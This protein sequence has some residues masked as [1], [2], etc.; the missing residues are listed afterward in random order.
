VEILSWDDTLSVGIAPID[1][2]H[3]LICAMINDLQKVAGACPGVQVQILDQHLSELLSAIRQHFASEE[4]L[5]LE[6][7]FPEHAAHQ[8]LHRL[9]E[10]RL[11]HFR[12]TGT[13]VVNVALVDFLRQWFL[14][15]LQIEDQKY[16]EFLKAH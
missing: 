4:R 7:A 2:E 5:L 12:I 6:A 10:A 3:R 15:H 11:E 16:A 9:L 1:N 13:L 8:Q 14:E